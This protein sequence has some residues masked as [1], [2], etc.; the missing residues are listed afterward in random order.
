MNMVKVDDEDD[1]VVLSDIVDENSEDCERKQSKFRLVYTIQEM[2]WATP[3]RKLWLG[4]T[5]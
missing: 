3:I 5:V 1:Y 4:Q 2:N